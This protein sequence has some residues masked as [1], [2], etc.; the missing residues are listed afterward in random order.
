MSHLDSLALDTV[1]KIID[2]LIRSEKAIILDLMA[3]GS[4]YETD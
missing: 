1:E 2:S 3:I 4:K